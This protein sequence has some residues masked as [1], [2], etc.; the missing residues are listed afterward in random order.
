MRVYN[1]NTADDWKRSIRFTLNQFKNMNLEGSFSVSLHFYFQRPK[2]HFGSG[3]KTKNILKDSSPKKHKAKP[4]LD[5]LAKSV[6]DCLTNMSFW[7]DDSQVT[8][9]KIRKDWNDVCAEGM[10]IEIKPLVE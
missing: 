6:L 4:D 9:L 2:S 8:E 5:N 10:H 7:I 1:P 3:V